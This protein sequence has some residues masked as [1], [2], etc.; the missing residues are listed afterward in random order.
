[1]ARA[2]STAHLGNWAWDLAT[3]R[4]TCSDEHCRLYGLAPGNYPIETFIDLVH[5]DDRQYVRDALSATLDE[6]TPYDVECRIALPDGVER[7]LHGEGEVAR[8]ADGRVTGMFG[9]AQDITERKQTEDALRDY[10][11]D[12]R[13]SNEDLERYAYVSSHDL[14]EPLRSIVSFSQLLERNYKGKLDSDADEYIA[15]IVEGGNRMQ[16]LI[17]DLL[18]YSRV[19]SKAQ[20]LRPTDTEA[21]MAAVERHLDGP[22]RV[23]GGTLTYDPLPTVTADPLQLELVFENLI[24]NAI[25]FRRPDEPLRIH[26]GARSL[27]GVWEF[28]VTDNGIGIEPEYFDRI[29]VIFQRLHTRDIYPGTGIGLAIVKRIVERHGGTVRVE[30][31]PGEGTTFFFTVPDERFNNGGGGETVTGSP[32]DGTMTATEPARTRDASGPALGPMD[33]D[34]RWT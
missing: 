22:L 6:G 23:A 33:G 26:I 18:A 4:I 14:Q 28:S 25:K 16:A 30:S 3:D 17:L 29:F 19:N 1:M 20:D 27:D 5:E 8:D 34:G 2:Q 24:G 31:A 13:R 9:I 32:P 10:A 7:V 21:V 12:L 11:E 15:F